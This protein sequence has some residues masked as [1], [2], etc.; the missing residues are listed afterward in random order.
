M[1]VGLGLGWTG[2]TDWLGVESWLACEQHSVK[3]RIP[4]ITG[5]TV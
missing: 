3:F 1:V 2:L 4:L 5:E